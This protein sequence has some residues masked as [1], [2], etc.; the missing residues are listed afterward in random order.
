M[1]ILRS[2]DLVVSEE[3]GNVHTDIQRHRD[4]ETQTEGLLLLIKW[5]YTY[6]HIYVQS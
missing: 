4:T 1:V 2:V 6:I 3:F 5:I